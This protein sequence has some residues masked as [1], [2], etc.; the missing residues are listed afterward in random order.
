MKRTYSYVRK[1]SDEMVISNI[2][3]SNKSH[4]QNNDYEQ[5]DER[6]DDEDDNMKVALNNKSNNLNNSEIIESQIPKDLEKDDEAFFKKFNTGQLKKTSD[7]DGYYN[8][9]VI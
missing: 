1:L 5:L 8:D 6:R 9:I 7:I 2:H 3:P 4:I